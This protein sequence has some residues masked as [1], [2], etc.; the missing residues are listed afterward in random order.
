MR[1]SIF[2]P[3]SFE[4]IKRSCMQGDVVYFGISNDQ[5]VD[6]VGVKISSFTLYSNSILKV[7][8]CDENACAKITACYNMKRGKNPKGEIIF[9]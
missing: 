2:L 8:G 4:K 6:L 7:E 5:G 1:A 3:P 9:H